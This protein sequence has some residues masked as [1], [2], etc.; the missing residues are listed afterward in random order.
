MSLVLLMM[1]LPMPVVLPVFMLLLRNMWV[2]IPI[3]FAREKAELHA[4]E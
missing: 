2:C 3:K 4:K 1:L